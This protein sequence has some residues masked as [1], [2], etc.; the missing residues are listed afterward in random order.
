MSLWLIG[1]L[2]T[3][4]IVLFAIAMYFYVQRTFVERTDLVISANGIALLRR[5]ISEMKPGESGWTSEDA[6]VPY[7]GIVRDNYAVWASQGKRARM[8]IKRVDGGFE[9]WIPQD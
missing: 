7:Q 3:C 9:V 4:G 1:F 8:E 6:F 5:T 2:I